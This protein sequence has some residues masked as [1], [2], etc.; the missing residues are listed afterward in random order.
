[1]RISV[2]IPY[3][4]ERKV[5]AHLFQGDLEQGGFL[6][7]RVIGSHGELRLE[8]VSA[9]LVD[10]SGW[11]VQTKDHLELKD[12]E[13]SKI[14][15]MAREGGYALVDCHSHPGSN[16]LVWFSYSDR[17]GIADFSAYVKWKLD[18]RPYV[19]MVWGESSI[20]AVAWYGDFAS[21]TT[22]AEVR[23]PGIYPRVMVPRGSWCRKPRNRWQWWSKS[24]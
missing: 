9:Y 22:V 12:T 11:E 17:C 21:P 3:D 5:Y 10:P 16:G 23:F 4:L 18:G 2:A 15:K 8:A 1:M 14:M 7:S 6:F 20:D 19:A 13:R 24:V